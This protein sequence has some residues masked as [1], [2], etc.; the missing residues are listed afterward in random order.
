[1]SYFLNDG[2]PPPGCDGPLRFNLTEIG[3][4]LSAPS[5]LL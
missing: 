3:L 1:M 4:Q 5:R 2:F